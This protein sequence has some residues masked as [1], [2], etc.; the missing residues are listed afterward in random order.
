MSATP[1]SFSDAVRI[2]R[3]CLDYAGGHH[4]D[5]QLEAYHHGI[6][7]VINALEAAERSGLADA[8]CAVL[9]RIGKPVLTPD[10]LF[11]LR[12]LREWLAIKADERV[13]SSID[14][15]G[16]IL[17]RGRLTEFS[18]DAERWNGVIGK[19]LRAYER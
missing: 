5:G 9:W 4:T 12:R 3:G 18:R 17:S 2:T 1:L 13:S 7:T 16:N 11:E 19:L 6:Q 14:S 10:D 15:N 8:Q